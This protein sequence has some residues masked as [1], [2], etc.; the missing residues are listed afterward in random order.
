MFSAPL[1]ELCYLCLYS[2]CFISNTITSSWPPMIPGWLFAPLYDYISPT[3]VSIM[4]EKS[5]R[6]LALY[7]AS[8]CFF[9]MNMI[10][11]VWKRLQATNKISS[12]TSSKM[13]IDIDL[14]IIINAKRST[15]P[16]TTI[17]SKM[18]QK[19]PSKNLL[20]PSSLTLQR[21]STS[22]IMLSRLSMNMKKGSWPT[23]NPTIRVVRTSN[24]E[25]P[26]SAM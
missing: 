5:M 4:F 3:S 20:I 10:L 11:R 6:V 1:T 26:I 18:F 21:K 14:L 23:L 2:I 13:I 12:E 19:P 8:F 15:H 22:T 24:S 16:S 9:A 25:T 7:Y 17:A